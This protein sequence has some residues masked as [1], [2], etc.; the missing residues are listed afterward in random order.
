PSM[1]ANRGD[2]AWWCALDATKF[3]ATF[4]S[5]P[6]SVSE[7][8]FRAWVDAY[9]AAHDYSLEDELDSLDALCPLQGTSRRLDG[10]HAGEL[11]YSICVH[12]CGVSERRG[13]HQKSP[14]R[15]L[16]DLCSDSRL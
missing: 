8:Q 13:R 11:L 5:P 6:A 9:D 16:V 2:S 7:A 1:M 10:P 4:L 3:E 15:T 12:E 14:A